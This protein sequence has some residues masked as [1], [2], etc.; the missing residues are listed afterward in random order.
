MVLVSRSLLVAFWAALPLLTSRAADLE[1][2]VKPGLWETT[3]TVHTAGGQAWSA[4]EL[5]QLPPQERAQVEAAT[6]A[7]AVQSAQP[8]TFTSCLTAEQLRKDL[9]FNFERNPACT[10]TVVPI[11]TSSWEIHEA[12]GGAAHRTATAR[13]AAMS[14]A[15]IS[16]ETLVSFVKGE[17][18]LTSKANIH[19]KWLGADCG[20]VRPGADVQQSN[21]K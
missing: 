14:P 18:R 19:S 15:E 3:T 13:F 8:H 20:N 12:C 17:R 4:A 16:G 10:R 1:V 2:A 7:A 21:G 11:S 5:A 9:T 6:K